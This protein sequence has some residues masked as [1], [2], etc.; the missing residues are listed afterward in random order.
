MVSGLAGTVIVR[1]LLSR[2]HLD[3]WV[4]PRALAYPAMAIFL[5]LLVYLIFF[6]HE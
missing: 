5:T 2:L 4:R 1:L 6:T 3:P